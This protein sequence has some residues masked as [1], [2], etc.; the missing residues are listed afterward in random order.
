MTY[1]RHRE[2]RGKGEEGLEAA[3]KDKIA[4]IQL[5]TLAGTTD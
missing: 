3:K 1:T 4:S 5:Q 2:S